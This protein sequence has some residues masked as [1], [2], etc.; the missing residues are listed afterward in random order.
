MLIPGVN[1][2][3]MSLVE[4]CKKYPEKVAEAIKKNGIEFTQLLDKINNLPK[5]A[6][7]GDMLPN[8]AICQKWV[9][10]EEVVKLIEDF[11]KII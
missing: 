2:L 6:I 10:W 1:P 11:Q 8:E 7:D 9:R 4:V 3:G 5:Y